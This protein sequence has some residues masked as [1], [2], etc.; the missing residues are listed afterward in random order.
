[1]PLERYALNTEMLFGLLDC[2]IRWTALMSRPKVLIEQRYATRFGME[3]VRGGHRS[4]AAM[5]GLRLATFATS[6]GIVD[7]RRHR[8]GIFY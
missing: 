2:Q 3:S 8:K 5:T 7:S 1:M 4:K 6:R